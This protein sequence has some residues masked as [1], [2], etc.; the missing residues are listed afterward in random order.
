MMHN[1]NNIRF[2]STNEMYIIRISCSIFLFR[3]EHNLKTLI[4]NCTHTQTKN[5]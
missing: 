4:V 3:N 1:N 5:R 2:P